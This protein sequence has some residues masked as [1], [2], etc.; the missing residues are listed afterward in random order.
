MAPDPSR[1]DGAEIRFYQGYR[2]TVVTI[3]NGAQPHTEEAE[4][5]WQCLNETD[6]KWRYFR[7]HVATTGADA[8]RWVE[9]DFKGWV[10]GH[11]EAE[12]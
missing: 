8:A 6:A 7:R 3:V 4:L 10:G 2:Y 5:W 1:L 12:G 11:M 9:S